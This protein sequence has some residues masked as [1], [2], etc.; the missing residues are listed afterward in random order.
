M[1]K[2]MIIVFCLCAL[3]STT[4]GYV[5]YDDYNVY[6]IYLDNE[7]KID[8]YS[9]IEDLLKNLNVFGE[10]GLQKSVDVMVGPTDQKQFLNLLEANKI[11]HQIFIENVG[12]LIEDPVRYSTR[13]GESFNWTTYHNYDVINSWLDSLAVAYPG[14]VTVFTAGYSHLGAEIKAVRVAFNS[15][16]TKVA[17]IEGGVHARE[18]I[19]PAT[20]TYILNEF[21]TSN[22]SS[23]RATAESLIWYFL[24]M[25]NPDGYNRT[26]TVDRMHRKNVQVVEGS[27]CTGYSGGNGIGTDLNR[28]FGFNWMSGG[29][30]S[31]PC[32]VTY[33]GPAAFSSPESR[34][35]RNVVDQVAD[36]LVLFLSFHSYSQLILLPYGHTASPLDNYYEQ[37]SVARMAADALE[38]YNGTRYTVGNTAEILYIASGSSTD[39][40]KG[41]YGPR[42]VYCFELRDSGQYGFLLP[43]DQIIDTSEETILSLVTLVEQMF[44]L[45]TLAPA[46]PSNGTTG[47]DATKNSYTISLTT[48]CSLLIYLVRNYLVS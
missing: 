35:L 40:V 1:L 44:R 29:S 13:S 38:A 47:S 4:L 9:E 12:N 14:V 34:A 2:S 45:D 19:G 41:T 36:D 31:N 3:F 17:V 8:A 23:I 24:P 21:L 25:C 26:F 5:N 48:A 6:R 11:D 18:W 42:I 16:A 32:S 30:S 43:A 39:W 27:N 28:N 46:N 20:V 15:S 37:Y 7:K 33:A 10:N 22:D